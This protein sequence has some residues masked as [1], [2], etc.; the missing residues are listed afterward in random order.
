MLVCMLLC[1]AGACAAPTAEDLASDYDEA[2]RILEEYNSFLP[3]IRE[4]HPEYDALCAQKREDLIARNCSVR[5]LYFILNDL[6][7]ALGYPAHLSMVD[8]GLFSTARLQIRQG[9]FEEDSYAYNLYTDEQTAAVYAAMGAAGDDSDGSDPGDKYTPQVTYDRNR[10]LLRIRFKSFKHEL[11]E[12]DR[13]AVIDACRAYPDAR[14]IVF[15]I[16]GNTGGNEMYW[17]DNLVAPFGEEVSWRKQVWFSDNKLTRA[18]GY[19]DGAEPVAFGEDSTAPAFV[20]EL[21]LTY[22]NSW[23][24]SIT[25]PEDPDRIIHTDAKRWVLTDEG[26]FSAADSFAG[27]CK[28]TKW[29]TLV[30]RQTLGDGAGGSPLTV[31]LPKTGLLLRFSAVAGAN[32]DGTL[33]AFAGT[34]PDIPCKPREFPYDTLLRIIDSGRY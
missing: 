17:V 26:T 13:N 4:R 30:G 21:G 14:H 34:V 18:Y 19:M 12:R 32:A 8:P 22:S 11:I 27:F 24:N 16:C 25:I 6:F 3:I 23:T 28:G 31:R 33:N 20:A 15:D 2:L 7:R 1:A 5:G 9:I 29:A 10:K